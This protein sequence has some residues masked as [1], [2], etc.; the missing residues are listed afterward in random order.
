LPNILPE[1]L[2]PPSKR[3]LITNGSPTGGNAGLYPTIG[4]NH[5]ENNSGDS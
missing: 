5:G 3:H 2:I 1:H 4:G